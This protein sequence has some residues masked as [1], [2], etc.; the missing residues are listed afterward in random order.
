MSTPNFPKLCIDEDIS[1]LSNQKKDKI[2]DIREQLWLEE[3]RQKPE[4]SKEQILRNREYELD[5]RIEKIQKDKESFIEK[6][7]ILYYYYLKLKNIDKYKGFYKIK[8]GSYIMKKYIV[9]GNA[10]NSNHRLVIY[11]NNKKILF[12]IKDKWYNLFDNFE[13]IK[14][15]SEAIFELE[16]FYNLLIDVINEELRKKEEILDNIDLTNISLKELI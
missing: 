12:K 5:R 7:I 15:E 14:F 16:E 3:Q 13:I 9:F 2:V 6:F 1:I 11:N 4:I 8:L 10:E